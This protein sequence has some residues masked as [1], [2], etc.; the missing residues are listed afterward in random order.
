MEADCRMTDIAELLRQGIAAAKA[1]RGQQARALLTQVIEQDKGNEQAWLWLSGVVESR[2]DRRLCLEQVL[3]INPGNVY[4]QAGL[5]QIER[6]ATPPSR[7][8]ENVEETVVS[9]PPQRSITPP[10]GE[11]REM[12][13]DLKE[14]VVSPPPQGSVT[15]PFGEGEISEHRVVPPPPLIPSW[16]IAAPARGEQ[17][18]DDVRASVERARAYLTR[19]QHIPEAIELL[20]QA[21]RAEPTN[22]EAYL[23]LGDAYLQQDDVAQAARYYS[24]A[25][26][27]I[28][29]DSRPG[30]EARLK[31]KV[32]QE[33]VQSRALMP[34]AEYA[35]TSSAADMRRTV[36]ARGAYGYAERPGC[37]TLYA[38]LAALVGILAV[39]GGVL[40]AL[41]GGSVTS[42]LE[43]LRVSLDPNVLEVYTWLTVGAGV[44]LGTVN[45]AIATGL[46]RMKNWARVVVVVTNILGVLIVVCPAAVLYFALSQ[47]FTASLLAGV[48]TPAW[49]I[50]LVGLALVIGATYWFATNRDRFD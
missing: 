26:R 3:A 14:R 1:G 41:A 43:R 50:P 18:E 10:F 11:K 2:D 9:P 15:P 23:L 37:V 35:G 19:M 17:V 33:S 48:P 36:E 16:A 21:V 28:A 29:P 24:H 5:R 20:E 45:V 13:V 39:V 25:S 38:A 31:L 44:V 7:A 4:A 42:L 49:V 32:L 6:S 34:G 30:R 47:I 27:H 22:G 8:R 12:G 40:L 46:W